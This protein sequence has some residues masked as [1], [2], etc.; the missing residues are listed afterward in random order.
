[1]AV[2]ISNGGE[3]CI[4]F[5]SD[6][7]CF[8]VEEEKEKMEGMTAGLRLGET[9]RNAFERSQNS[10]VKKEMNYGAYFLCLFLAGSL[11]CA[12]RAR[13]SVLCAYFFGKRKREGPYE[14]SHSSGIALLP[15]R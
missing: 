11:V 7:S 4:S 12:Q 3:K 15:S 5:F 2:T 10:Q 9:E 14:E 13:S 8:A 6:C 1:M